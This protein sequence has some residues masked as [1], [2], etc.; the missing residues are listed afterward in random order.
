MTMCLRIARPLRLISIAILGLPILWGCETRMRET[1]S[2]PWLAVQAGGT[3][4][5]NQPVAIPQDRARVFFRSG[6]LQ[7]S[8]ANLGPS[9]GLEVRTLARDGPHLIP[10]G[11]YRVTRVQ[12]YW[13][14]VAARGLGSG[15]GGPRLLLASSVGGGGGPLIQEG[16][17]LWLGD[18]PDPEVTRLTCLGM[19]DEMSRARPPTLAEIR[20]ALGDLA[21][22]DLSPRP[23]P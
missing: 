14:E 10:A 6:R 23:T 3:L 1:D 22:L 8:G 16:Y 12:T 13:S 18:G 21:T 5:L 2:G 4:T 15:R 17:H 20:V 11:S 9:C 19:L 7:A